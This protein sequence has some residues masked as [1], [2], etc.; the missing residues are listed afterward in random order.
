MM[1]IFIISV[2]FESSRELS[3]FVFVLRA[4]NVLGVSVTSK[5]FTLLMI[6]FSLRLHFEK[7]IASSFFLFCSHIFT[8]DSIYLIT[9]DFRHTL[10]LC[11]G[12]KSKI[13]NLKMYTHSSK[14]VRTFIWIIEH[15]CLNKM[16]GHSVETYAKSPSTRITSP[17]THLHTHPH[18]QDTHFY[19]L[20]TAIV[21]IEMKL[22][23][24]G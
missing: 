17:Y 24:F 3:S 5:M 13:D 20:N 15:L 19:S 18:L 10:W 2:L 8:L 14:P 16:N 11:C 22:F 6:L 23:L 4:K 1:M 12:R 9:R 21:N 7:K